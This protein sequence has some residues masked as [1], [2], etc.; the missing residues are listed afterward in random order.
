MF[1]D[2]MQPAEGRSN[3]VPQPLQQ[4]PRDSC[5]QVVRVT[6]VPVHPSCL[7]LQGEG[8]LVLERSP[9][10][11]TSLICRLCSEVISV[12][13]SKAWVEEAPLPCAAAWSEST[14]EGHGAVLRLVLLISYMT[15]V[16]ER[17]WTGPWDSTGAS[18][19][20]RDCSSTGSEAGSLW[21]L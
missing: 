20:P 15:M 9:N 5:A 4:A 6:S 14:Q 2:T 17:A 13:S 18:P 19:L 7:Q 16:A 8:H 21:C 11:L 1:A 12:Y 10:L 3:E